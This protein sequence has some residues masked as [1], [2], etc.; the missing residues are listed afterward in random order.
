MSLDGPRNCAKRAKKSQHWKKRRIDRTEE[1]KSKTRRKARARE[2]KK[3]DNT[4]QGRNAVGRSKKNGTK[5]SQSNDTAAEGGRKK[6]WRSPFSWKIKEQ[7]F[8]RPGRNAII[9]T[10]RRLLRRRRKK[11][12][13]TRLSLV[14]KVQKANT[15]NASA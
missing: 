12:E 10:Q 7:E 1:K 11:K 9:S 2:K 3:S 5:N 14:T 8:I 13:K 6:D 15:Q 4:L